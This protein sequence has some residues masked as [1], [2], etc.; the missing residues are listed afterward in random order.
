PLPTLGTRAREW[1][2][3]VHHGRGFILV[4]GVPVKDWTQTESELFFWCLGQHLGLP[5]AQNPQN[6]LLGHV[7]DQRTGED[8]RFYRTNKALAVHCDTADVVGLL[9]LKKARSGG[10]SRI[11]SSVAVYNELLKRRPDLAPRL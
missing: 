4:R 9:C 2:D 7:R 10:L 8:V 11:A 6:D 3:L 1:T 5:G